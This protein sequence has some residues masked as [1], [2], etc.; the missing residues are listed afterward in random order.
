MIHFLLSFSDWPIIMIC[1]AGFLLVVP[2]IS[3]LWVGC[4]RVDNTTQ[5]SNKR[6]MV[7]T[8]TGETYREGQR[9]A[10]RRI[11]YMNQKKIQNKSCGWVE[12]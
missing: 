8:I 1:P 3:V 10:K 11:T 7:G 5:K 6:M 12:R 9:K 2:P 4:K